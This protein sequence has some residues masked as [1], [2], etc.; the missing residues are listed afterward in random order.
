MTDKGSTEWPGA[1]LLSYYDRIHRYL[2]GMLRDPLEAEDLTQEAFL[3]AYLQRSSLRESRALLPWLY[4]IATNLSLDRIRQHE[5]Y[6][7][8]E[9]AVELDE[10]PLAH[11]AP[12]LPQLVEQGEMSS[13]VRRYLD[14]MPSSHR[15]VLLLH[16]AHGLTGPEIADILHISLAAMKMRLHRARHALRESLQAGC[17]FS[18]DERDVLVC[19][20]KG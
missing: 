18:R 3:H 10:I 4:R 1:I 14:A 13:C 15:T 19:E 16:D 8:R 11:D 2:L 17:S 6:E 9:A 12:P 20:P 5:R 7:L